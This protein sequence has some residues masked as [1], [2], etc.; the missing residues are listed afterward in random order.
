MTA[1][2]SRSRPALPL[3]IAGGFTVVEL[4]V[5]LAILLTLAALVVDLGR[6]EWRREQVNTVVLQLA[7]W[8]ETVR[9]GAIQAN[10]CTVTLTGG[11]YATGDTLAQLTTCGAIRPFRL[12]GLSANQ[13]FVLGDGVSTTQ[14][15]FTPAGTVFPAPAADRPIVISL[16]LADD[17]DP[18]PC[19][20][21][22]GLLGAIDVGYTNGSSCVIGE[23]F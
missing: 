3:R 1:P 16:A 19:L 12:T 14:F 22:D 4:L 15:S 21:L 20:Q 8:L 18:Q 5:T 13:R 7:G 17:A 10:G 9:R 2:L 11:T 23:G 6:R